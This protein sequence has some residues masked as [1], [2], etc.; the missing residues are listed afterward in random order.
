VHNRAYGNP[1]AGVA[2]G[3]GRKG[4]IDRSGNATWKVGLRALVATAIPRL[5][6]P[7][8]AWA[9]AHLVEPRPIRARSHVESDDTETFRLVT[10]LTGSSDSSYRV[11]FD[12][13]TGA[14]GL[15]MGLMEGGDLFLG[16]CGD[17]ADAVL[18][19]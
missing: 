3:D 16:R 10:D 18:S 1:A 15:I 9:E 19:M 2:G 17:F 5:A 6:P 13:E 12:P 11:V 7:Y 8:R 4:V 14:F